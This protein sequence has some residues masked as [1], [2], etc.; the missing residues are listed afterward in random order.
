MP[1][2]SH[3]WIAIIRDYVE[4]WRKQNGWSR[5]TTAAVIVE[6]HEREGFD[7]VSGIVFDPQ[8]RDA[9]ER[10]RVN[11]DRI[12]RWLDD[13]TKDNNLLCANFVPSIIAALPPELRMHLV[14]D[15]LRSNDIACRLIADHSDGTPIGMLRSMMVELAEASQAIAALLDGEDPGELEYA[16][17]QIAEAQEVLRKAQAMVETMMRDK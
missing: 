9:Y 10:M 3:T 6:A 5:E 2:S 12:F 15:L 4:T 17:Q 16:Q 13:A 7:M 14:D 1:R 8:T 11:A